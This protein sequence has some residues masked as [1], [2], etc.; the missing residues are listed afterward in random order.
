MIYGLIFGTGG[1]ILYIHT[2]NQLYKRYY[3][4][5][6]N[7]DKLSFI[8]P[9]NIKKYT[10]HQKIHYFFSIIAVICI[11][12]FA[13]ELYFGGHTKLYFNLD[14]KEL[15]YMPIDIP[16]ILFINSTFFYLYHRLAHTKYVY[17]YIHR[18]HH[19]YVHPEPFDSLL[20][21]PLDH[22][23]AG[24]C[25]LMPMFIYK[26]H[27]LTFLIYTSIVSTMGIY[28]H[29]GIKFNFLIHNTTDHHVHHMY[30]SKNYQAG[31]PILIWDRLFGTYKKNL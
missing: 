20:G 12:I 27:L 31:F 5:T 26:T 15:V 24:I 14:Y 10:L 11:N 16:I 9:F 1:I 7:I 4:N 25:Q 23:M 22:T 8:H 2:N 13:F 19:A 29:S 21:H 3:N 17:K 18:Y 6:D 28:E 30:P